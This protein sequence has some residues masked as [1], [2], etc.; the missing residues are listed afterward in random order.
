[1]RGLYPW[2]Y[3]DYKDNLWRFSVNDNKELNYRIMYTEGKWTKETLIDS[4]VTGFGLFID[5]S[6]GIH[7]VYSNTKGELRYCTMKD[8]KWVGKVLDK[9]EDNN[10][11]IENIKIKIIGTNMHIFYSLA[12]ED[13][14]DHGILMHCIWDGN[15]S[16]NNKLQDIILKPNLKEYYLINLSNNN[17]IYLFYLSDEGDELSLN[18]S[19]YQNRQ[20]LPSNRLYGIQG[21]EVYFDVELD[22]KNIHILNRSKE[23]SYYFLDHVIIDST[24]RFKYFRVY[25]GKNNISEPLLINIWNK[26]Y[27]FW[28]ENNEIF[29]SIFLGDKWESEKKYI[30]D[31][32]IKIER[33]NAYISEVKEGNIKG[34]SIYATTGLDIYLYDPKDLIVSE[35][36]EYGNSLKNINR[37][38]SSIGDIEK[39]KAELYRVKEENKE[40]E[41]KLYHQNIL[42]QKNQQG[43]E[44]YSQQLAR[45][46]EQKRK[47]EENSNIFLELQKKIQGDNEKLNEEIE[48]LT[49]EINLLNIEKEKLAHLINLYLDEIEF[50]KN[51][52]KNIN[53]NLSQKEITMDEY[54]GLKQEISLLKEENDRL[55]NNISLSQSEKEKIEA[56]L[57]EYLDETN[58]LKEELNNITQELII[59]DRKIQEEIDLKSTLENKNRIILEENLL[60]KKEVSSLIEENKRIN[61]EFEVEKNKS[62]MEKLL[63]KRI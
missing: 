36:N 30:R 1:M 58:L 6:E 47:A 32:N 19:I 62:V 22:R 14:S 17:E 21:E 34:K 9:I 2:L 48:S 16:N 49:N 28:I 33:C 18:Y 43:I 12:S 56:D 40:L 59:K 4:R 63:R 7:L 35:K 50:L 57:K 38:I 8:K 26:T 51:E 11:I 13:G 61:E 54:N 10:Y 52:I 45:A 37:D 53:F 5:D 25:E 15:K 42:L 27:S 41:D 46:L 23:N 39:I 55:R 24:G 3:V 60:I 31:K 44:K 20:W 29:Y